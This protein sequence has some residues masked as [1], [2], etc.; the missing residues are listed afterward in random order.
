MPI[1]LDPDFR[2]LPRKEADLLND[3]G[4]NSFFNL[5][6]W[7]FLVARFGLAKGWRPLLFVN[8][9]CS[10]AIPLQVRSRA[11][12]PDWRSCINPYTCEHAIIAHPQR[13]PAAIESLIEEI[14]SGQGRPVRILLSGLDRT[15]A[16][17]AAALKRLGKRRAVT[18]YFGW[19]SWYEDVSNKSFADY[20]ES[21][22]SILRNTWG[23]KL[24]TAAKAQVA[25]DTTQPV[26]E[27]IAAY[28]TVHAK[29]WKQ[30]EPYPRFLPELLRAAE[31]LGALRKG[32]LRI[33][34]ELAAAQFWIVWNKRALIFK[35]VYSEKL[36][37]LSPG[38][39]LTM[40]MIEQ[41]LGEDRPL[42][43]SFGRGDDTYKK[44]WVS[45]RREHWGIDAVNPRNLRGFVLASTTAI[46]RKAKPILRPG[47]A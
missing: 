35:L 42:E 5:P 24:A 40:H 27:F 14:E 13:S 18:P 10:A 2:T 25:F 17:F 32:V 41:I 46:A 38:T 23:R 43:I 3:A 29:S 28:E 30:P 8:E 20:V 19:G 1:L 31:S 36:R 22:P 12:G 7:Y 34:S 21:R 16:D 15:N 39:L 26:E 45:S 37:D 4:Q 47:L 6:E 11:F 9:D 44:L 33:G